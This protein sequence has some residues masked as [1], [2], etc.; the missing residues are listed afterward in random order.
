[1]SITSGLTDRRTFICTALGIA[2]SIAV[3]GLAQQ[4]GN[5]GTSFSIAF[6]AG[7]FADV[8][9]TDAL[10]ATKVW[11]TA[12]VR[13]KGFD[14]PAEPTIFNDTAWITDALKN[15]R[16]DIAVLLSREYLEIR[17]KV[18]LTPHFVP[19]RRGRIEEECLL[20]VH[21]LS[22]INSAEDLSGKD[23]L[24]LLS[25]K[26]GMGRTW[27]ENSLIEKGFPS[28]EKFFGK[29]TGMQKAS[30]TVLPVYF[31]QVDACLVTRDGFE[32]MAEL[33]PQLKNDLKIIATSPAFLP[34]I[35]CTRA[36][37]ESP[38]KNP[39]LEALRDLHT[40]P[41]GQQLLIM[42]KIDDLV[43]FESRYLDSA[44]QLIAQ[45]LKLKEQVRRRAAS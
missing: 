25:A 16:V 3:A 39:A 22:G 10:A 21:R 35:L 13:K 8:N 29:V 7:L 2:H 33:N 24:L 9:M 41:G 14:S 38:Y 40:E 12:I 27:L 4:K 1:V 43:P 32:T 18:P 45:N 36:N 30:R 15:Q 37:Y 26:G 6:S 11:T 19:R 20:L 5:P 23:I 34:A 44:R 42:F 17:E 28:M 31:R